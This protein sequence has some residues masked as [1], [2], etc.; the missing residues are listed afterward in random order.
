MLTFWMMHY[1]MSTLHLYWKEILRSLVEQGVRTSDPIGVCKCNFLSFNY[2]MTEQ[3]TNQPTDMRDHR[4]FPL[5]ITKHCKTESYIEDK[6][7]ISY[8]PSSYPS[9]GRPV[10]HYYLNGREVT[11]HASIRALVF[12]IDR[13]HDCDQPEL[14][15]DE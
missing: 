13:L 11:L 14:K 4:E 7:I 1:A 6:M 12:L 9:I 10:S 2:F 5:Q 8:D 3:P 15:I